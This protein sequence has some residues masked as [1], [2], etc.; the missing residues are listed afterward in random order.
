MSYIH[1]KLVSY[2]LAPRKKRRQEEDTFLPQLT[3]LYNPNYAN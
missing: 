1:K 3:Q 2:I